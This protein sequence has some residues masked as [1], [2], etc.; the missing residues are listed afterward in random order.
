MSTASKAP[1][2]TVEICGRQYP[3]LGYVKPETI[4]QIVPLVDI[5]QMSDY[6]WQRSALQ[7][8]LEHP[9]IYRDREDLDAAIAH[10]RE[11]LATHREEDFL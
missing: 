8:R 10:L 7:H 11:W 5:P 9:E 4:S 1:V 3:V 6:E 2:V